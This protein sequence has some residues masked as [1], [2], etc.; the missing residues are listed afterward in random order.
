MDPS[1]R[2][3]GR[4][5]QP[6]RRTS[7]TL[8][9]TGAR[10]LAGM[11]MFLRSGRLAGGG[12]DHGFATRVG[13]RSAG[14]YASLSFGGPGDDPDAVEENHRL[15]AAAAGFPRSDLRTVEQVHGGAVV[16][17]DT[18]APIPPGTRADA[19]VATAP[20]LV[21]AVRTA[22]CVPLLLADPRSGRVAAVHA[23]WRGAWL[24]IPA[25]A[26][27]ELR[28]C[29]SRPSD[30]IAAVGPAIGR[31]CYEVSDELASRFAAAFGPAVVTGRRLDLREV[32]RLQ[33]FAAGIPAAAVEIVGGCTACDP[34][35]HFSHRRDEGRTGRH[36]SFVRCRSLS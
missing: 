19:L 22:D 32:V 26:V 14:P 25:A 13:G 30:L 28:A 17:L 1:A 15:L 7:G 24:R 8:P 6:G 5:A 4:D 31:C 29:G 34:A 35:L 33:L 27:A 12:F 9:A 16:L 3:P 21:P 10:I 36:L 18:L 20:G 11:E 23:G 2:T